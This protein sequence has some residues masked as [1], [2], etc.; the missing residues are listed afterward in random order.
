[1]GWGDTEEEA[2]LQLLPPPGIQG[3][4]GSLH[5]RLITPALSGLEQG[6][7]GHARTWHILQSVGGTPST[8]ARRWSGEGL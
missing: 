7:G 4:P 2:A 5:G 8:P 6:R 3:A 1:M